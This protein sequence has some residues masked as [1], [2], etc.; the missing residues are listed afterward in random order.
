[1][2]GDRRY[3]PVAARWST[4]SV[5]PLTRPEA[6]I[7]AKRLAHVFTHSADVSAGVRPH[8]LRISRVRR[9]WISRTAGADPYKGWC[10]LVH[11]VSHMVFGYRHPGFRLHEDG[12]ERL[13]YEMCDFAI[14]AGW[15]GGALKP[16]AL[17]KAEQ[18]RAKRESIERRLEAWRRKEA[19]AH[20]AVLKLTRQ[21]KRMQRVAEEVAS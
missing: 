7:A 3:Q 19:R 4:V 16:R 11:D 8:G 14:K 12:H 5:P 6:E 10:R 18:R 2:I 20:R 17:T 15:L 21:L 1:M 13:E 9:C